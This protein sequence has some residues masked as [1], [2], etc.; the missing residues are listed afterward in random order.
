LNS[1]LSEKEK[2]VA[3]VLN[4]ELR[5]SQESIANLMAATQS[6]KSISQTTIANAVKEAGLLIQ[7]DQVKEKYLEVKQELASL[8]FKESNSSEN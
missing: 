7:L 2:I 6:D 3:Y 4:K 5:Y 8:G 1:K